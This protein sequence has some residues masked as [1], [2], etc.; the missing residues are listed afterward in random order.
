MRRPVKEEGID[1]FG[2]VLVDKD[3]VRMEIMM[4]QVCLRQNLLVSSSVSPSFSL[5]FFLPSFLYL[6]LSFFFSLSFFS[7][8]FYCD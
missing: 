5:P 6:S 4:A 2:M 7:L 8:A 1:L 3:R